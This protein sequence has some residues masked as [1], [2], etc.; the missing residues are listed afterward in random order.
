M[1]A[2]NELSEFIENLENGDLRTHTVSTRE[3]HVATAK[4]GKDI[5]ENAEYFTFDHSDW[6]KPK[7]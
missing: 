1:E 4:V 2:K 3:F 5:I 7:K 6:W